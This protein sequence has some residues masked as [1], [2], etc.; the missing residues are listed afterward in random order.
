MERVEC[1]YWR[2]RDADGELRVTERALT[3]DEA[4]GLAEA[5]RIEG[6]MTLRGPEDEDTEPDVFRTNQL[7]LDE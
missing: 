5:E 3:A 1:W 7:P 6:S 2:Y 4:A